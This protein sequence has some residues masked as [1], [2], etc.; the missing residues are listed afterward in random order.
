[1]AEQI[2]KKRDRM[3]FKLDWIKLY[4]SRINNLSTSV[5]DSCINYIKFNC[6]GVQP[7]QLETSK[8]SLIKRQ[9]SWAGNNSYELLDDNISPYG[10]NSNQD[11]GI[12]YKEGPNIIVSRYSYESRPIFLKS[13]NA[14]T[15]EIAVSALYAFYFKTGREAT[16]EDVMMVISLNDVNPDRVDNPSLHKDGFVGHT[17]LKKLITESGLNL[18]VEQM[19]DLLIELLK[20]MNNESEIPQIVSIGF[21]TTAE[22]EDPR[23][24]ITTIKEG[25]IY[26][27]TTAPAAKGKQ[28]P[29]IFFKNMEVLHGTPKSI[30]MNDMTDRF[31]QA[32]PGETMNMIPEVLEYIT[33]Y[34]RYVELA[35]KHTRH[36]VRRAMNIS[37]N[38]E[39]TEEN[40]IKMN[41]LKEKM[42]AEAAI[43]IINGKITILNQYV[44][45]DLEANLNEN[46]KGWEK[47]GIKNG[48]NLLQRLKSHDENLKVELSELIIWPT[49]FH[50]IRHQKTGGNYINI[51]PDGTRTPLHPEAVLEVD[52]KD[53]SVYEENTIEYSYLK[54]EVNVIIQTQ[55][56]SGITRF[57]L[58]PTDPTTC[59]AMRAGKRKRSASKRRNT[60][61]K[62]NKNKLRK[63]RKTNKRK[64]NKRRSR[65]IR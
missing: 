65:K 3:G 60:K 41:D 61:K 22:G 4:I 39:I 45:H 33:N 54:P 30:D 28:M 25:R 15:H 7:P 59:G 40:R 32:F 26:K 13:T 36:F 17:F 43:K 51:S 58:D 5:I 64:Q 44:L 10:L 46:F 50:L 18:G 57:S 1:M 47:I 23:I 14:K 63:G 16:N 2:T 19:N 27:Y 35:K 42:K 12:V 24:I 31:N 56:D 52:P 11:V 37:V 38:E 53:L 62:Q 29:Q 9:V 49:G 34:N 6:L 55:K 21:K 8:V 20:S 48:S